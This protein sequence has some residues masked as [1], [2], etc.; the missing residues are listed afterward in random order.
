MRVTVY[1]GISVSTFDVMMEG[2][3]KDETFSRSLYIARKDYGR[4]KKE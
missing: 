3:R 2:I 4:L 1:V